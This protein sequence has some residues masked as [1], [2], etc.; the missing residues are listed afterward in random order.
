MHLTVQ[1]LLRHALTAAGMSLAATYGFDS[2]QVEA[3]AGALV[4]LVSVGWSVYDSRKRLTN[5]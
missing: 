4:T 2:D 3:V 1:A 5:G